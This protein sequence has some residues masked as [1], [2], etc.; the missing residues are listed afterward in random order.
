MGWN[1]NEGRGNKNFK[2]GGQAGSRGRCLKR[3]GGGL[4][5]PYE[6]CISRL[7]HMFYQLLFFHNKAKDGRL[8]HVYH[9]V[10]LI[11]QVLVICL[12]TIL[13]RLAVMFQV[14][15]FRLGRLEVNYCESKQ[16]HALEGHISKPD[17]FYMNFS[18]STLLVI[19]SGLP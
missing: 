2:K 1:R 11:N 15:H 10:S 6:L 12:F 18:F 9:C 16:T 8:S 3:M 13:H 4:E 19:M 5:P 17:N 7:A 14:S